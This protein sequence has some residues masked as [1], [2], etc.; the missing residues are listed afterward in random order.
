MNHDVIIPDSNAV[1]MTKYPW[2]SDV[3]PNW[4]CLIPIRIDG[5]IYQYIAVTYN[6]RTKEWKAVTYCNDNFETP[7][8]EIKGPW[9]R[10]SYRTYLVDDKTVWLDLDIVA[11]MTDDEAHSVLLVAEICQYQEDGSTMRLVYR[12][13][14]Y[15]FDHV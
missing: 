6:T 2:E 4:H 12:Y 11:G 13:A 14:T 9:F 3:W 1:L 15:D 5:D 8:T 10:V 7:A